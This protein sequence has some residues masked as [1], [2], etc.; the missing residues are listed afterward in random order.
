MDSESAM[1]YSWVATF[2]I[3]VSSMGPV[4]RWD[5][6]SGLMQRPGTTMSDLGQ[7]RYHLHPAPD[8]HVH[9]LASLHFFVSGRS[10]RAWILTKS[11]WTLIPRDGNLAWTM[12]WCEAA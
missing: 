5:S 6:P 2:T 3:S 9:S 11:C 12:S 1:I 7:H 8:I 10:L 4:P